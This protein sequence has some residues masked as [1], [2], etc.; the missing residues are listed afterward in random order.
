V[1]APRP[2]EDTSLLEASFA[3][4]NRVDI[5]TLLELY[6][7][8]CVWDMTRFPG[9]GLAV[10]EVF[11]GHDGLRAFLAEFRSYIEP[12][13]GARTEINRVFDL[14]EGRIWV[15][16]KTTFGSRDGDAELQDEWIQLTTMRGARFATVVMYWDPEEARRD[17]G[18]EEVPQA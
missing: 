9:V 12:W 15:D 10:S 11:R 1:T 8:D 3:A 6:T 2:I 7:E 13:G 5:D 18:L 14:G 17:A 4:F 16:G